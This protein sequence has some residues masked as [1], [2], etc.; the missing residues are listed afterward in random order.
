MP[1]N[2]DIM[3][4]QVGRV[5]SVIRWVVLVREMR[6]EMGKGRR[7]LALEVEREGLKVVVQRKMGWGFMVRTV[8]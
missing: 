3:N 6:L 7:E 5:L 8:W 2:F 1:F 4:L